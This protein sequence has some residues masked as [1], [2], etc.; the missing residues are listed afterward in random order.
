M[1]YTFIFLVFSVFIYIF[2]VFCCPRV[3]G[4][5]PLQVHAKR[6]GH[7]AVRLFAG[8][9]QGWAVISDLIFWEVWIAYGVTQCVTHAPKESS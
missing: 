5:S 9:C 4:V 1:F 3:K 6:Q 7:A 2:Y 8:E